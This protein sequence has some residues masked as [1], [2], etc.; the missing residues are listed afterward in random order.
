[1]RILL[2]AYDYPPTQSPRALRWR[3]LTRELALLGHEVHVLVPDLGEPG[4]ELPQMPGSVVVHRSFPGPYGWIVGAAKRRRSRRRGGAS[5]VPAGADAARLN[6]RGRLVSVAKRVAGL[7]LFPD[8]RAEWNPWARRELRRLLMKVG[9][10]VVVTSHEPASTLPLGIHAQRLG[11]A[12][13]ADLGDPVCAAYTPRRWHTRALALEARVSAL[14]DGVVVTNEAT[15]LLLVERHDQSPDRCAVLPNGYDD[16]R[17]CADL[18]DAGT[19]SFDDERLELIYAGRLYGYRDPTP[20]LQAVAGSPGVRLT[21]IVPDPP[22]GNDVAAMTAAA[23]ERLRILGLL[24]H[25][26]VQGL[27]ER[28]DVLVNLGDR[29]QPVRTPAKLFEYFGISRPIL[30]VHSDGA[31]AAASLL[32]GL[33][34]SWLCANDRDALGELLADLRE[35]KQKGVLHHGLELAPRADY[36]HSNLGRRLEKLLSVAIGSPAQP[37][38]DDSYCSSRSSESLGHLDPAGPANT[39][40]E[41]KT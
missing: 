12:W 32:Y 19:V 17:V 9:P 40:R 7:F 33:R 18:E 15:R 35:R 10:D 14:A 30:H 16:R 26:Q 41:R 6:W 31:D 4:I 29:G 38:P 25:A 11:F 24:P 39:G 22:S 2:V 37:N 3:Y 23:G 20:L 8:V 5:T 1:M 36:A 28:A 27:L 34:R 13:V 21:L